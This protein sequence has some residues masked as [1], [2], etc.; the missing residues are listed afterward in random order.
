MKNNRRQFISTAVL[1]SLSVPLLGM[2][3]NVLQDEKGSLATI[4]PVALKSGDT[5]A[6]SSP[7]G[8]VWDDPQIEKF[9]SILETFGFKVK[10]GETLKQKYG[11]F[12][13]TDEFR[14]SEINNFFLDKE[15]KAIF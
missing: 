7:A 2:K 6:I 13:G 3:E 4:K 10:L 9:I 11:Y 1:A 14:A 8:A 5:V 12:A 15:V